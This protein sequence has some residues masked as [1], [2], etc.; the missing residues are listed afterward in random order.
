VNISAS[1]QA[2]ITVFPSQCKTNMDNVRNR[3]LTGYSP[4]VSFSTFPSQ[5]QSSWRTYPPTP[6]PSY[7]SSRLPHSAP[8]LGPIRNINP[9]EDTASLREEQRKVVKDSK[10]PYHQV[11]EYVDHFKDWHSG[12]KIV[13]NPLDAYERNLSIKMSMKDWIKLSHDLNYSEMDERS[14]A[15]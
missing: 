15:L 5:S 1:A 13:P 6:Q 4:P 7:S 9:P 10:S 3:D 2:L 8:S 11:H 12:V 14:K